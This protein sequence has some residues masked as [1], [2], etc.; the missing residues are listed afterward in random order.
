M[1]F[2]TTRKSW[3]ATQTL[4][5]MNIICA[6]DI[7]GKFFLTNLRFANLIPVECLRLRVISRKS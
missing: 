5:N 3:L 2:L 1:S 7:S 4:K 6:A